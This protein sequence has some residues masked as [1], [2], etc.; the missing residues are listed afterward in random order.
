MASASQERVDQVREKIAAVES[1]KQ[2]LREIKVR[3][4]EVNG[5]LASKQSSP[6]REK[7]PLYSLVKRPELDA[8]DVAELLELAHE[9]TGTAPVLIAQEVLEQ[10]VIEVKYDDYPSHVRL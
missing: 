4:D 3:P 9:Q 8:E 10:T 1:L 7:M 5:W 2:E 6:L